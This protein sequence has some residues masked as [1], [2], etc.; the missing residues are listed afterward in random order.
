MEFDTKISLVVHKDLEIWQKLNVT[1]FLTSGIVCAKENITRE[2]YHDANGFVYN[3]LVI[4]PM[5]ILEATAEQL[6]RT[7]C[8]AKD[9]SVKA[10]VFI[11]GMFATAHDKANRHAVS[12]YTSE[13]LPLVG[14]SM[15]SNKKT[16]DKVI[17]RLKLHQ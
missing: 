10:S 6:A 8:R 3:P 4:Q 12:Q 13:L 7:I 16:I 1:E 11:E 14:V 15:R 5:I 9:R 17:K 2:D